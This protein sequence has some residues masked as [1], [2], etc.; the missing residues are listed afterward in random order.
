LVR[1]FHD[2]LSDSIEIFWQYF[3]IFICHGI[4]IVR[5]GPMLMEFVDPSNPRIYIPMNM[6]FLISYLIFL[7]TFPNCII[8]YLPTKLRPHEHVKYWLPMNIEPRELKWFHGIRRPYDT[9]SQVIVA[10]RSP[11][12]YR[13]YILAGGPY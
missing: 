12:F 10:L 2:P 11:L 5:G 4:I 8:Y 7:D 6:F 3:D 9:H 13:P 1:S